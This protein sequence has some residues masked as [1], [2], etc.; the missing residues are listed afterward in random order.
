MRKIL[1]S[2]LILVLGVSWAWALD[3]KAIKRAYHLSYEFERRGEYVKAREALLPV[4]EKFPRGYT[5]NLR[6]GWLFYLEGRYREARKHYEKAAE[7]APQAV[8]PLL[9][10]GLTYMVQ[11]RW[12][13]V[14]E[15][16]TRVLKIDFYNYYGNLRLAQALREQKKYRQAEAVC[17]KMLTLYPTDVAFLTQLALTLYHSGQKKV[18]ISIFGDILILDPQNRIASRFVP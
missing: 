12:K 8:E 5:V 14:E 10:L 1:L 15:L 4:Y 2:L 16:M 18:A 3:Y 7:V 11:K 9:G 6:L 13:E 17:R